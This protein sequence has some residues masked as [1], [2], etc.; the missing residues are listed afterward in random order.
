MAELWRSSPERVRE[1]DETALAYDKFR[2]RYPEAVFDSIVG[3]VLA[4]DV[5]RRAVE[6]G[7][8]TGIATL[9]LCQ[10]GLAVTAIEPSPAMA[11]IAQAKLDGAAKIVVGRFE[12]YRSSAPA[13]LV[14]AFNAWH[15]ID[16][17]VGISNAATILA[18]GGT[19]A[20]VWT[21]VVQY[22]QAPFEKRLAELGMPVE[23][24][25]NDVTSCV[26][27]V[28][29]DERF[30]TS[31]VERFP[32]ERHLDAETFL[33]VSHTYGGSSS[34]ERDSAVRELITDELGGTVIKIEDAVVFLFRRR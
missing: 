27:A 6:V 16:P 34:P 1:F 4:R 15:W 3:R 32:F 8:G 5:P 28:D 22:G 25:F 23:S 10:R 17:A 14:A 33:A 18:P 31:G 9:P 30:A 11:A 20:L 26:D 21:D 29:A 2:P 12:E 7:A 13:G 19:F 24:V